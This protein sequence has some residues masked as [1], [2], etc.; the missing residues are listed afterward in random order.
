[1]C[2]TLHKVRIFAVPWQIFHKLLQPE[3]EQWTL[4]TAGTKNVS[5]IGLLIIDVA[6]VELWD[7]CA[8]QVALRS[9][10]IS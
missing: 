1:M 9:S 7:G 3:F 10:D 5:V 8:A 2:S 4:Q 6:I